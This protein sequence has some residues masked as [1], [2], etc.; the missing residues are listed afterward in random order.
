[1]RS[2]P[3]LQ[4]FHTSVQ[5]FQAES[6]LPVDELLRQVQGQMAAETELAIDPAF[7]MALKHQLPKVAY[8][9][10]K[11]KQGRA[12]NELTRF[13]YQVVLHVGPQE[14]PTQEVSWLDWQQEGFS[15]EAVDRILTDT[16]PETLCI[17]DVPNAR[18]S[19]SVQMVELVQDLEESATAEELR[20]MAERRP[21]E[22]VHPEDI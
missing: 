16:S 8:V 9:E 5:L 15:L 6:S 20:A 4:S 19:T 10:I 1:V 22:G 21:Q 17:K 2:L 7:F 13:R 11:P 18:V 14:D 3:L 12:D